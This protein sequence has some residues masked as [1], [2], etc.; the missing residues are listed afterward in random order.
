MTFELLML[1][2][3]LFMLRKIENLQDGI[4]SQGI[5]RRPEVNMKQGGDHIGN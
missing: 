5:V 4:W 3:L 2:T 1:T